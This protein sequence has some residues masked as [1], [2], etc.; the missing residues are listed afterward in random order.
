II[1]GNINA[2]PAGIRFV[3]R[4]IV[5]EWMEGS[6]EKEFFTLKKF[7][8]NCIRK[9]AKPLE[10]FTMESNLHNIPYRDRR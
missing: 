10:K 5:Q 3:D 4:M 7:Q 9:F 1:P 8:P 2:P 6:V